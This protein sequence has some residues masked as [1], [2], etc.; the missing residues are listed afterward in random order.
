M[1]A[2]KSPTAEMYPDAWERFERAVKRFAT[3]PPVDRP[4]KKTSPAARGRVRKGES[5]N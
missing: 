1:N 2:N 3:H 5:R 4:A